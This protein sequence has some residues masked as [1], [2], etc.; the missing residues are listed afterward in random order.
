MDKESIKSMRSF[1][2][3]IVRRKSSEGA[4]KYLLDFGKRRFIPDTVVKHGSKIEEASSER[5][6]YWVEEPF[7]P[8]FLLKVFEDRR[9]ALKSNKMSLNSLPLSRRVM[10]PS[11]KDIFSYL[12]SKT[13]RAENHQC[14]HCNKDVILRYFVVVITKLSSGFPRGMT[15]L[16]CERVNLGFISN[17]S[18]KQ[19]S[20][21]GNRLNQSKYE[22]SSVAHIERVKVSVSC[23]TRLWYFL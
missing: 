2:K 4:V 12:L 19:F 20:L 21:K 18:N 13:E 7:V 17:G 3:A 11:K 10:K 9:I 22:S 8:L 14:G 1:K 16:F 5:K 23:V 15:N 6:K